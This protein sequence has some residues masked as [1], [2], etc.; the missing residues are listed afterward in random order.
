VGPTI[1]LSSALGGPGM[2]ILATLPS[3]P[4]VAGA[5]LAASMGLG[6]SCGVIYNVN[7]VSF[8]QAITPLDM[9]GRMNATMRFIVWGTMPIGS[10]MGGILA[11]LLPL[12][13]TV[14]IAGTICTVSFLWVLASPVRSLRTIPKVTRPESVDSSRA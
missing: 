14:L 10:V 4:L 12:R 9:Q 3:D 13:T 11:T 5:I 1:I 2:I 6:G 7:Q 8:R